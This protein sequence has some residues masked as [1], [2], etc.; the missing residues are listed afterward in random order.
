V[1]RPAER[2]PVPAWKLGQGA[3]DQT[4]FVGETVKLEQR[5]RKIED[6]QVWL[7]RLEEF[8][9]RVLA[10]SPV[11]EGQGILSRGEKRKGVLITG[12][13]PEKYNRVIE[14]QSK[15]VRGRFFGLNAGEIAIGWKLADEFAVRLGDKV[16]LV[17]ADDTAGAYTVAGIFDTGFAGLD[18]STVLLPLR[19][20][21][22][23]FG[24]GTAVTSIGLKITD[25]FGAEELSG[26]I[27]QQVPYEARPWTL[28]NQSLLSGLT[29]QGQSSNLIVAFTTMAAGMAIAAILVMVVMS[30]LRELGILK[31]MGATRAQ[32][33][34]VF[35]IQGT[36]LALVGGAIGSATGVG[37]CLFLG[38]FRTPASA[39]GRVVE[40][41]PMNLTSGL[42]VQT[43]VI[44]GATGFIASLLPAWRAARINPIEVIRAS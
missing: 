38:R 19:D 27:A 15:L 43:L 28:D 6:W 14:L 21:Q 40:L 41:F 31:A 25:V 29:A 35:A 22:S 26:R 36:L 20:A 8:D 33:L 39:T 9:P 3:S 37:F 2:F 7:R 24:L 23:L 42:V 5:K 44:A 4:I 34:S 30:K 13:I 32:I 10:V 16:R 18:S 12:A 17:S 1:V 11:V